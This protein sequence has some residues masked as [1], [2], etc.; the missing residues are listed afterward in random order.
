M[1]NDE[2]DHATTEDKA[3]ARA[4]RRRWLTLAE[5]VGLAG[6]AIAGLS[7]WNSYAERRDANQALATTAAI[8]PTPLVLRGSVDG[9]GDRLTITGAKGEVFQSQ[10]VTLPTSLGVAPLVTHDGS[11]SIDTSSFDDALKAARKAAGRKGDGDREDLLPVLV[12]TRYLVDGALRRDSAIYDVAYQVKGGLFGSHVE[13]RGLAFAQ[14]TKSG[15]ARLDALWRVRM[16]TVAP[17][18]PNVDASTR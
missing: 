8:A 11:G 17:V 1:A 10:T 2:R 18:K 4:E 15:R 7:L 12:D 5:V 6:V 16:P 14:R 9:K 3:D 13:L